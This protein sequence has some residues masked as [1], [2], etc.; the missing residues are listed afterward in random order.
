MLK[1]AL[2]LILSIF[3]LSSC[4]TGPGGYLKRSANNKL[5]DRKGFQGGKRS[6]LYNKKY[7]EKAKRNVATSS[8]DDDDY[9]DSDYREN[10]YNPSNSENVS[11]EN[12][13]MYRRMLEEDMERRNSK[14]HSRRSNSRDLEYPSISRAN[15]GF[16]EDRNEGS[17]LKKELDEIKSMLNEAKRDIASRK[18]PTAE[19]IERQRSLNQKTG[20]T[21]KKTN[22]STDTT[23]IEPVKSI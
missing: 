22:G 23:I 7:I 6:P 14:R 8:F 9:D 18:C 13:E 12:R 2:V 19:E 10:E 11:L 15:S 17:E 3:I 21:G 5:F 20:N 1:N 4:V 16:Y